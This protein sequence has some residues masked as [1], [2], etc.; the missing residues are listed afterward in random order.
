MKGVGLKSDKREELR[1]VG[2]E[3]R[4]KCGKREG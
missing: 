1:V 3:G 2:N 4:V